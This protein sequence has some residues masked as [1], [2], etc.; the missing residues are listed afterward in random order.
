MKK[1]LAIAAMM[2]VCVCANAQKVVSVQDAANMTSKEPKNAAKEQ[3]AREKLLKDFDKAKAEVVKGEK[4]V[5]S[6]KKAADKA[7]DKVKDAQKAADKAAEKLKDAERDLEKLKKKSEDM[8]KQVAKQTGM[9]L[10]EEE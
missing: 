3:K 5:E 2:T 8:G 10:A 1:L 6:A 9:P 4:K 7:A